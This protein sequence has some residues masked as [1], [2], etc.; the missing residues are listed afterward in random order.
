M[1]RLGN[2]RASDVERVLNKLGYVLHHQRGSHRYYVK[3]NKIITVPSHKGKTLGK[4][5]AGKIITKDLGIT[6]DEFFE[7]L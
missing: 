2:I 7:L 6:I 4:G 1:S 5:L 3:D